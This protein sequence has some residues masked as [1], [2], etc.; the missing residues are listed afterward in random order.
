ML[1]EVIH[2]CIRTVPLPTIFIPSPFHKCLLLISTPLMS[3]V[4]CIG[5]LMA[6]PVMVEVFNLIFGGVP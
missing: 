1:K 4:R 2:T 3:Y 6:K 5:T